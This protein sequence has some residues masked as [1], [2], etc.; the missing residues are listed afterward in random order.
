[1]SYIVEGIWHI[2]CG[3]YTPVTYLDVYTNV[4]IC[5]FIVYK[6]YVFWILISF[7]LELGNYKALNCALTELSDEEVEQFFK[8]Q[9]HMQTP[10]ETSDDTTAYFKSQPYKQD[11]EIEFER[12]NLDENNPLGKGAFGMVY[13]GNLLTDDNLLQPVAVKTCHS[14]CDPNCLRALLTEIKILSCIGQHN[15]VVNLI[16]ACTTNLKQS[17]L[18]FSR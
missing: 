5:A 13:K 17:K 8:G 1:M 6:F 14:T 16:G 11:F 12:L 4:A 2:R 7:L 9:R 18:W 10:A 3:Y 15:N